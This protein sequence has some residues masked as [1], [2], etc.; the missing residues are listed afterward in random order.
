MSVFTKPF[1][2][3]EARVRCFKSAKDNA[4]YLHFLSRAY[5]SL[6]SRLTP[7]GTGDPRMFRRMPEYFF[8]KGPFG[9][10]E[11]GGTEDAPDLHAWLIGGIGGIDEYGYDLSYIAYSANGAKQALKQPVLPDD[12][13]RVEKKAD[14]IVIF[15]PNRLN[16]PIFTIIEPLLVRM[17]KTVRAIDNV[18]GK[19]GISVFSTPDSVAVKALRDIDVAVEEGRSILPVKSPDAGTSQIKN[20]SMFGDAALTIGELWESFRHFEGFLWETTGENTVS[21]EKKERLNIPEVE[22]NDERIAHGIFGVAYAEMKRGLDLV[23]ARWGKDWKL[24]EPPKPPKPTEDPEEDPN[25][26]GKD[27]ET[28]EGGNDE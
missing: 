10:F 27:D 11:R 1:E 19:R 15:R 12:P 22:S 26:P 18:T 28:K 9:V 21:F 3:E 7:T 23:N 14:D 13:D 24:P 17:T 16:V 25:E 4:I 2:D 5:E 8:W 20:V 6:V